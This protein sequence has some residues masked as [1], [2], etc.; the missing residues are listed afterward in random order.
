MDSSEKEEAFDLG[1]E[2]LLHFARRPSLP[3]TGTP[4]CYRPRGHPL[5]VEGLRCLPDGCPAG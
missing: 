3:C 5:L 2:A 1:A 4:V